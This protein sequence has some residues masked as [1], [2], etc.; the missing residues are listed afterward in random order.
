MK[1]CLAILAIIGVVV[2]FVY[3]N[4]T[5]IDTFSGLLESL[6]A[7]MATKYEMY[8]VGN[9][10]ADYCRAERVFPRS[11]LKLVLKKRIPDVTDRLLAGMACDTW[12]TAYRLKKH[13]Q[14]F[15]VLSAGPDKKWSTGDD[16]RYYCSLASSWHESSGSGTGQASSGS[17]GTRKR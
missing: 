15:Y 10:V 13:K 12:G 6:S 8:R 11:N 1:T 16:I 4:V 5:F 7:E 2:W 14:G 9:I 3:S 17:G